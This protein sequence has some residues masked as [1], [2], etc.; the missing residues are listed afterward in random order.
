MALRCTKT[1]DWLKHH[2][3]V[4]LATRTRPRRA[5]AVQVSVGA[6]ASPDFL[7]VKKTT[8]LS[9]VAENLDRRCQI[10]VCCSDDGCAQAA[11]GAIELASFLANQVKEA[12]G[13]VD[14][15][16]NSVGDLLAALDIDKI[17]KALS[18]SDPVAKAVD[19]LRRKAIRQRSFS[20]KM[21]LTVCQKCSFPFTQ[22]AI[23][24][25][26][27]RSIPTPRP[28]LNSSLR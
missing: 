13:L 2:S 25:A 12:A 11:F 22:F 3:T 15:F 10:A 18:H 26:R 23:P 21:R 19:E 16:E 6:R 4:N 20:R 17:W 1:A 24:L 7:A 28:S 14:L 27:C 5:Q 9:E 8:P